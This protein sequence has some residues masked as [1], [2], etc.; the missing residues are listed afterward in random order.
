[1]S[2]SAEAME[3]LNRIGADEGDTLSVRSKGS[4]HRGVLMPHHEFSDPDVIVIKLSSGY[5]IGIR[6]SNIEKIEVLEKAGVK[7]TPSREVSV[8]EGR[9]QVTIIGT[10]GTI[11]S[12][13]DYRTGGVHPALSADD[14]V[15]AVPEISEI[16]SVRADVLFSIYSE[17]MDVEKWRLLA[18]DVADRLN[19]GSEGIII[20]HGTDTMGYTS[21]AL[22]FMLDSLPRAVILVGA[23]RSSDRPSSDA[24]TNLLSAA[25]IAVETDIAEVCV[26]MHESPSDATAL[27]H[28]G[29]RVRKLHT[30]RRDAFKTVND[31]PIAKVDFEGEI[32]LVSPYRA[33]SDG[34]VKLMDSMVEDVAL[35]HFF[36]G[37]D[38]D[39]Y[40]QLIMGH[41]GVVIAGSGLGHVSS[42]MVRLLGKAVEKGVP[43]AMTSQCLYGRVNLNVYDTGR[44]LITAG[45]VPLEDMLPETA[46]VKMM[47]VLGQTSDLDEVGR[48]MRANLRGEIS[49]RRELD[50]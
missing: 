30:S 48:M 18:A 8:P 17:N 39:R 36:P 24:Y 16:C 34:K 50:E 4:D 27:V 47:W 31:R 43:V 21:A 41:S 28:R 49:E 12:Y 13:V 33:K 40:E 2:Y 29:T 11:A 3:L 46:L 38:P 26:L 20:P 7:I 22:A 32:E 42:R 9:K 37:M 45:V 44:D 15:S 35:I 23:Q 14:L 10:G 1:M 5:N 6:I 19:E 25:R